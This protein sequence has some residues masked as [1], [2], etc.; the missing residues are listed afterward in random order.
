[1]SINEMAEKVVI[2]TISADL[3]TTLVTYVAN[4][5]LLNAQGALVFLYS[6]WLNFL[7]S[8]YLE[9]QGIS[10]WSVFLEMLRFFYALAGVKDN[11]QEEE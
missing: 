9:F 3:L 2:T 5:V 10:A 11:A 1:M 7:A 6:I 4:I 8:C